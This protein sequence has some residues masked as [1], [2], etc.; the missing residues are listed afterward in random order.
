MRQPILTKRL[1]R[2]GSITILTLIAVSN[3]GCVVTSPLLNI[4]PS[5]PV[6]VI[7][8]PPNR[9]AVSG[10]MTKQ[11]Y[12]YLFKYLDMML[13][14]DYYKHHYRYRSGIDVDFKVDTS[15]K[16]EFNSNVRIKR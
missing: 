10:F 7:D 3:I 5:S 6:I 15:Q 14:E 9:C 11:D 8:A 12:E 13:D 4:K 1:I 16:S 2:Y